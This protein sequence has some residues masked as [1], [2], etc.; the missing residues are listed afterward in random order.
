MPRSDWPRVVGRIALLRALAPVTPL[1]AVDHEGM[2]L[3]VATSDRAV[4]A[5][6]F[7]LGPYS[8]VTMRRALAVLR[9]RGHDITGRTVI[10]VG[11]NIGTETVAFLRTHGAARVIAIEAAPANVELLRLNVAL[12]GLD[13]RVTVV[14]AA[15][16]DREGSVELALSPI[17]PGDH[18]VGPVVGRTTVQVP[19]V[20]LDSLGAEDVALVWM[21]VQGHEGHVLNGAS[22]L[23]AAG[24]PV[25]TEYWPSALAA[26][27]RWERFFAIVTALRWDVYDL[28]GEPRRVG[29]RDLESRDDPHWST[30]LLLVPV[31]PQ[32]PA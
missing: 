4:S 5:W 16:S 11:A 32:A 9:E 14:A 17:N 12:N 8:S 13:D 28:S 3:L 21:D 26:A 1:A 15:A 25:V 22:D 23:L 27:G 7:A 18:R 2:R 6:T 19:A 20:T 31:A 30:D 10:E 24:V 29:L